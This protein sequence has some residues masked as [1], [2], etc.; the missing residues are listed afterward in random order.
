MKV[1]FASAECAPFFK[2]GGLGDVAGALPKE[3]SKKGMEM[4]V[5]LPYF[6]KMSDLYKKQ[7]E[8]LV[9]FSVEVGWRH[10]YCGIKRLILQGVTYYFIDNLYYFDRDNLYGYSD[11]N[12]RFAFFSLAIIKMLEKIE[13]TPDVIHVND[14][15]T[16]MVPFL[17]K[18]SKRSV[19]KYTSIKTILTIHNIEFQGAYAKEVLSDLFGLEPERFNENSTYFRDGINYLKAGIVYADRINTVSPTYAEEIKTAEFGFGL[20]EVLREKQEKLSGI[21]NGID[22]EMNDP[23]TDK[24][25]SANFSSTNLI[26]KKQD[27][28]ALQQRLKLPV[29]PDIPLIAIVS[30]LTNQKGFQ[31]VVDK[32]NELLQQDVQLILLGTGE[33]DIEQTLKEFARRYPEK[34]STN[35]LFDV[36]LAQWIYAGAD[37]FL[38]PSV[39]EPCGLSQMIA[40]RYGT[41]PVVHEIGGLKD[42]VRPYKPVAKTGTGFSFTRFNSECFMETLLEAIEVYEQDQQTWRSLMKVAMETDFSWEK[43][44]QLYLELYKLVVCETS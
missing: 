25:I 14:F 29:K 3:L 16:A 10:Q 24:L 23:E 4:S 1:L 19:K 17:L 38:M 33:N 28:Q 32:L 13:L 6:T 43:S 15:H 12:E 44:G 31:L 8:D 36:S 37:L 9:E 26:G 35:I 34:F 20:D 39:T 11:D 2:T 42:T 30:R 22:Y 18:E 40:M 41:L 27:K 5:V 21:V 7:C